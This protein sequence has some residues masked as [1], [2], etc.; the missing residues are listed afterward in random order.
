MCGP[1][2]AFG[3][4]RRNRF[5][6]PHQKRSTATSRGFAFEQKTEVRLDVFGRAA[7]LVSG[8]LGCIPGIHGLGSRC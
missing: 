8:L 7:R 4:R 2:N 5:L 3:R 6:P 1:P